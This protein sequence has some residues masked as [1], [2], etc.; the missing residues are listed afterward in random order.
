MNNGEKTRR[1]RGEAGAVYGIKAEGIQ[2]TMQQVGFKNIFKKNTYIMR[3]RMKVKSVAKRVGFEI[4]IR[5]KKN[6]DTPKKS[7]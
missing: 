2:T 4:F 1:Y 6:D 7:K 3:F 5:Q